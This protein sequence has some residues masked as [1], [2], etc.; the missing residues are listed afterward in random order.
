MYKSAR[1]SRKQN[2]HFKIEFIFILKLQNNVTFSLNKTG[3]MSNSENILQ[4]RVR[5]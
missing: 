1:F 4:F 5:H 3:H 2:L